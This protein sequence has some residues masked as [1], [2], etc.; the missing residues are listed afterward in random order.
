MFGF[1]TAALFQKLTL[2]T[3]LAHV[4]HNFT[5]FLA[6]IFRPRDA[7]ALSDDWENQ[8][9]IKN[10]SSFASML[11]PTAGSNFLKKAV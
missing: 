4:P 1:C 7:I 6:P 9:L 8:L 2:L 5:L 3:F 11:T 10:V